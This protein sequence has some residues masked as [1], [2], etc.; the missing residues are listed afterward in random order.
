MAN[1]KGD[2]LPTGE[3]GPLVGRRL[4]IVGA[5]AT[6][7]GLTSSANANTAKPYN[8]KNVPTNDKTDDPAEP[9]K[10]FAQAGDRFKIIKGDQ[11]GRLLRPEIL[12]TGERPVEAFPIEPLQNVMRNKNRLNRLLVLRLEPGELDDVTRQR[13]VEGVLVY[14][15]LCTHRACT[16]K[17]WKSEE[18]HM[19][20]H[21][22]LSEFAARTEGSVM[23]GPAKRQLPMIPLGID[24]EGFVVAKE[25][26]TGKPGG[27][28]K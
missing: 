19:R 6:A 20:C 27:A 16:I 10:L 5:A 12:T 26:F 15:A 2:G 3:K 28:K 7:L 21:C 11:R 14:S 24:D 1:D 4:V 9:G 17:S 25:G 23:A 22:H 8:T 18:R 13:S